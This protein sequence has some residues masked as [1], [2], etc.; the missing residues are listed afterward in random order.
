MTEDR[1]IEELTAIWLSLS[2]EEARFNFIN[3]ETTVREVYRLDQS[4][5]LS[6]SKVLED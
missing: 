3:D 5:L 1:S 2:D 6:W 4:G